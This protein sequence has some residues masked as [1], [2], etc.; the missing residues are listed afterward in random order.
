MKRSKPILKK[1]PAKRTA[2]PANITSA[3]SNVRVVVFIQ[4][5][6]T[7]DFYF[8]TLAAWGAT[9]KPGGTLLSAPPDH[10]Q[11]HNRNSWVHYRMGDYPA[12]PDQINNDTIIPYYSWLAK[13][14]T[15]S[16]HHFGAGS[17][18]TSGHM[19]A[20]GG[21]MPT[22]KNPP[23]GPGG[24]QWDI[25]SI[26][27][28]AQ[29][30]GVSW[31]VCSAADYYPVK[32]YTELN[33]TAAKKNIHTN[34]GDFMTLAK[35]GNLPRL[36]Y[37]WAP[38]GYDE[39][40]PSTPDPQYVAKGQ[41]FVWEHV[42]AVV[43]AG[44][45][46]NTVFILTWDDWGG[47]ADHVV[48]P[49]S[50]RVPDALHPGGFQAIGGS[51]IPLLMFGGAVMQGIDNTWHSHASIP[52]TIIDLFGLPK[53]GVPR[54]DTSPSLASR[55]LATHNR[56]QPPGLG[57]TIV[58]PN[59]PVPTPRPA[60]PPPWTGPVGQAMPPLVANG[61]KTIPAPTDGK[62]SARPPSPPPTP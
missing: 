54:V 29:R 32:F 25:P 11:P 47:Y 10:D 58:Q 35:A 27:T 50:E 51:R 2:R 41:Q 22:M 4:E 23:F 48:T 55:V 59:P 45:W 33:T 24:P 30:G 17:D 43:Q 53:F 18:S 31:A 39:H 52:K 57:A 1:G 62:V 13:T 8:P 60:P 7:T 61:G 42:D 6:K 37:V 34:A 28:H 36:V 19:L 5:N 46:V 40:P 3:A 15:F 20:V 21:Q 26:F 38:T 56:P 49:D 44:G 12:L 16:D 9:I 14:Y